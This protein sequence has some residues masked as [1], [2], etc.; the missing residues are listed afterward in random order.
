MNAS[1]KIAQY[2]GEAR[3]SEDALVRVLQSQIAMTP[4]GSYRSALQTHLDETR[5][6]S[7]RVTG[8]LSALDGGP[9]PLQTVIGFW[10]D[11]VG[12]GLALT[13]TPFDLL[14]GSGGEEKV[15]KNAKDAAATEAL[16]IATYTAIE[17]LARS[18]GDDETADLAKSILADEE[19]MLARVMREIPKLTDA[20]LRAE[21]KDDPSYDVTKTGAADAVREAGDAAASTA[22]KT[23]AATRRTARKARKVPGVAQA[24]GQVKGAVAGEQDLAI[25]RYDSLTAEEITSKLS[26]LS[27]IDLAKIDSY[28]RKHE[29]RT[30]VLSRITSLRGDEPWP[31]YDELTASEL[32]SMLSEADEERVAQIRAYERSH[33]NRAGVLKA[34]ERELAN[35]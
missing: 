30:T 9:T 33:K 21:L 14:R 16:E 3:A 6:H 29:N 13:K 5:R 27:Q 2:L 18:V 25:T 31:G 24:E 1:Q 12:Q 15:L 20:V 28:E 7:A 4:S 23:T 10:E 32:Q 11:I 34:A 35:A 22:R 8:R 17:R 26:N 19:K